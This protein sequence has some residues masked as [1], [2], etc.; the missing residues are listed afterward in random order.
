MRTNWPIHSGSDAVIAKTKSSMTATI[1]TGIFSAIM[2]IVLP[3]VAWAKIN[4]HLPEEMGLTGFII[5]IVF[6]S[7][8]ALIA[9]AGFISCIKNH[10]NPRIRFIANKEGIFLDV[11]TGKGKVF[12]AS[13]NDI[14]KI[15]KI[16]ISMGSGGGRYVD[17]AISIVLSEENAEDLPKI[18]KGIG[19]TANS[20]AFAKST[21]DADF[22]KVF[23]QLQNMFDIYKK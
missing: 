13:W 17:T 7:L 18:I 3:L 10:F 19:S 9:L 5:L 23:N 2:C 1:I 4:N 15:E 22:D 11:F 21:L 12:F 6:L 14:L 16:E 8:F 20:A